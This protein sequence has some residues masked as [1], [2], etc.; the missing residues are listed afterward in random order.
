MKSGGAIFFS[1]YHASGMEWKRARS[2]FVHT[3][4]WCPSGVVWRQFVCFALSFVGRPPGPPQEAP[5][6]RYKKGNTVY[7]VVHISNEL[8]EIGPNCKR[9][10]MRASRSVQHAY[11]EITDS[12]R[13]ADVHQASEIV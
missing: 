2:V 9:A 1:H 3:G 6:C 7:N 12:H 13:P 11:V 5:S 4:Q 8:N 10:W